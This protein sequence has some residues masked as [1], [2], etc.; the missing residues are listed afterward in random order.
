MNNSMVETAV[1]AIVIAIAAGFFM[2]MYTVGGVGGPASGYQ[3]SASF[4]SVKGVSRGHGCAHGRHQ[5]RLC[6][7]AVT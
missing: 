6:H 3:V 2:F 7:R 4:G 5:D 1:G